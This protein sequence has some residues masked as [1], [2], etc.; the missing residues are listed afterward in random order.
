M[1]RRQQLAVGSDERVCTDD[2]AA[3]VEED[4]IEV[5]YHSFT[6]GNTVAMIAMKWR[7]DKCRRV[8]VGQQFL[9]ATTQLIHVPCATLVEVPHRVIGL[10]DACLYLRVCIVVLHTRQHFLVFGHNLIL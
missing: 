8:R 4:R 3:S 6:D 10:L 5:N 9:L 1:I 2:D 7:N